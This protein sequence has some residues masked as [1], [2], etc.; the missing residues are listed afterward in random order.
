MHQ[1]FDRF[2]FNLLRFLF[3]RCALT[4]MWRSLYYLNLNRLHRLKRGIVAFVCYARAAS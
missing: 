1:F 4:F 2:C 3:C